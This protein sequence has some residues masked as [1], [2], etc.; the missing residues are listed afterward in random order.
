[1]QLRNLQYAAFTALLVLTTACAQLG[2]ATPETFNQKAAAAYGTV[3]QIR[4]TASQLN[5]Q[6]L[7]SNDDAANV[8]ASTD[9]AR[10]GIETARKMNTLD[11]T[12]ADGKLEA[13]RAGLN[14]VMTYL[15][16]R[17]KK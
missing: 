9:V 17:Q 1:M 6:K 11:P 3:T 2:L 5:D 13:I 4:E 7:I 16:S 10:T 8:L 12:A 15:A 14:A